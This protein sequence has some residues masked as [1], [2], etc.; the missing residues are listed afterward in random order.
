MN[1]IKN[2]FD[3]GNRYIKTQIVNGGMHKFITFLYFAFVSSV[4]CALSI[5]NGQRVI[6]WSIIGFWVLL[7]I[8]PDDSSVTAQLS[9]VFGK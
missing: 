3:N 2:Y 4:V 8:L 6:G 7:Q 9:K 1:K 5:L